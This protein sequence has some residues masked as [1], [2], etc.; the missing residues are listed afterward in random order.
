MGSVEQLVSEAAVA[1]GSTG[2]PWSFVQ[3]K[4]TELCM[5]FT[6]V[7]GRSGHIDDSF[8]YFLR[9]PSCE[10]VYELAP[11]VSVREVPTYGGIEW[12]STVKEL[13]DPRSEEHTS[14]LQSP[15]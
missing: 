4:G 1:D 13:N 12:E 14:E 2:R 5:D 10:R 7:C 6:C 9:C 8:C 11:V 3:W 15:Y